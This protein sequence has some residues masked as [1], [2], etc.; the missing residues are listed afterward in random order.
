MDERSNAKERASSMIE[1]LVLIQFKE[2]TSP[3][4]RDQILQDLL[5]LKDKIPGIVSYQVGHNVSQRSQGF[6]AAISSTFADAQSLA[7]YGPHPLHQSA[8][9][10]LRELSDNVLVVDFE[11]LSPSA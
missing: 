7:A 9:T 8:A 5:S 2:T 11:P 3:L 4:E 6:N 1:H 10:R